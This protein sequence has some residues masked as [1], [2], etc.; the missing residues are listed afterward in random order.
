MKKFKSLFLAL[1]ACFCM[2][3][4]ATLTGQTEPSQLFE[5]NTVKTT[6]AKPAPI[7]DSNG[8]PTSNVI[9]VK[10]LFT[11]DYFTFSRDDSKFGAATSLTEIRLVDYNNSEQQLTISNSFGGDIYMLGQPNYPGYDFSGSWTPA[12]SNKAQH[13]HIKLYRNAVKIT[14]DDDG[15][16]VYYKNKANVPAET[17]AGFKVK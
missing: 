14:R 8:L 4:S 16:S 2:I 10:Y 17:S 11:A 15:S 7:F 9:D 3:V 6:V 12:N 13:V 1:T 5:V